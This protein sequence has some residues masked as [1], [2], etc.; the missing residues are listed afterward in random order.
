MDRDFARVIHSPSFRRLQGKTQLFP[1]HESD[2]FRNRLTHSLEV[3]QIA[4]SIARNLNATDPYLRENEINP[5][6]CY[7]AALLHDIGHPPFGHNGEDALDEM[8]MATGGFEGNAQTLRIVSQLEKKVVK[9]TGGSA[10]ERRCGLNLTYRQLASVLKYDNPIPVNRKHRDGAIKGYYHEDSPV[11]RDIKRAVLG[12]E[13]MPDGKFKT[14]ECAIMDLADDIAYSTYDLEDSFKAGFLSP[15]KVLIS[16]SAIFER[17]AKKVEK[18]TEHPFSDVNAF[19]VFM[20]MFRGYVDDERYEEDENLEDAYSA[21]KLANAVFMTK[22]IDVVAEDGRIRTEFTSG[23]VGEFVD[24]VTFVLNERFPSQSNISV[25]LHVRQKIE[26]LKR[27]TY[28]ATIRSS[29]LR[30]AEYRG[31][32]IVKGI[33][34]ALVGKGGDALLP[35]DQLELWECATDDNQRNRVVCDFIAGMTDRYAMEFYGR[36]Y[37]D[38]PVSMF[39]SP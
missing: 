7:T 33:F 3:A 1:A 5:R 28:E 31:H 17:V 9:S 20:E 18:E 32:D 12:D 15:Y 29:R 35:D 27:F 30:L 4:E 11:V 6:I 39:K 22:E 24:S 36:L 2:F 34:R 37:S 16:P 14:I 25:P 19:D 38:N 8:M 21:A 23:L 10:I 13:R 26:T